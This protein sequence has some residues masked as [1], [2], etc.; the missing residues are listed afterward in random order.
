M[1]PNFNTISLFDIVMASRNKRTHKE[2]NKQTSKQGNR[3]DMQK[4][5][6]PREF[7]EASGRHGDFFEKTK[8]ND[9]LDKFNGRMCAKFQVCIVFCLARRPGTNKYIPKCK[10]NFNHDGFRKDFR[11]LLA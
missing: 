5:H 7:F 3:G 4:I 8:K 1:C 6:V 9:F 10:K 2:S 11:N